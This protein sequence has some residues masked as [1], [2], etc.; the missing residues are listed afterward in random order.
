MIA[1]AFLD[2]SN[3]TKRQIIAH[4]M[5]MPVNL[6]TTLNAVLPNIHFMFVGWRFNIGIIAING[7]NHRDRRYKKQG[8]VGPAGLEPATTRL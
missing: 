1:V 8:L 6:N 4:L 2:A 3:G 7:K 5:P